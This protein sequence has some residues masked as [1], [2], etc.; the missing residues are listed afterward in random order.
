MTTRV[1]NPGQDETSV[2][3]T[4]ARG[5]IVIGL[6]L[7]LLVVGHFIVLYVHF[8]PAI[9]TP[10]A[11]GYFAQARLLAREHQTWFATESPLQFIPQHWLQTADGRYFSKYPPG[12]PLIAAC[13]YK[14]AGPTGALLV[15][16][17]M[18]SLTLVGVFLVCRL[19]VASGWGLLAATLV[20]LNPVVNQQAMWAFAHTAV[21]CCLIWGVYCLARW[22]Q[23]YAA[24][25]AFGAGL[26]FGA[27][28][29]IRYAEALFGLGLV[30]FVLLNLRGARRPWRSLLAAALGGALPLAALCIRNHFAFGAFWKTGYSLTNE[31]T[32]F[33]WE[34]FLQNALSYLQQLMGSGGGLAFGLGVIAIALMCIRRSTWKRGLLL[35]AL[36][37][38]STLLYM[39]Y[40][41]PADGQSMRFLLPTLCLY[42]IG[43]VWLLR[44]LTTGRRAAAWVGSSVMLLLTVAWGLPASLSLMQ[45]VAR[46]NAAL[47]GVTRMVQTHVEPGSI[48]IAPSTVQQQLDFVGDWKLADNSVLTNRRRGAPRRRMG[49]EGGPPLP[50]RQVRTGRC[51]TCTAICE[52]AN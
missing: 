33:G 51:A 38:P 30:L 2:Q 6:L 24:R 7:A 25:W 11:N 27:I 49:E 15:N 31:Q 16:P 9:S 23:S 1:A 29:T 39:C 19:W 18:A 42:P 17:V 45:Q 21:V 37:L 8:E 43:A 34:Y 26:L 12:L 13:V 48:I 50:C 22:A 35:V 40:Y 10:D 28:P 52:A 36:T 41:W 44:E 3:A 5:T 32:G 47:A 14:L 4:H 46:D 20:A